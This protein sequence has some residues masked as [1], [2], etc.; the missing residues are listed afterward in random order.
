MDRPGPQTWRLPRIPRTA[1]AFLAAAVCASVAAAQ[2]QADD[3]T[4]LSLEELLQVEVVSAASKFEQ[5]TFQAPS[6]ITIVSAHD[7]RVWGYR[8]LADILRSVPGFWV[9]DDRNYEHIGVR[10]FGPLGDYNTRVLLLVDGHRINNNVYDT[11]PI[12]LEFPLDVELIERVEVVRGP[13][14]ALYGSNAFFGVVNVVTRRGADLAGPELSASGGSFE[15]WRGR[16]SWGRALGDEGDVLLSGTVFDSAGQDFYYEEYAGDPSGGTTSGTDEER[17]FSL[18]GRWSHGEWRAEAA[19]GM[20]RKGIPTGSYGTVFDHPGNWTEDGQGYVDV[21]WRRHV[22]ERFELEARAFWDRYVYRGEYVFDATS[23]GGPPDLV[24]D[25]RG[26]GE[27]AGIELRGT[28]FDL[29]RQVLTVGAELRANLRMDQYN[30]DALGVYT[31]DQRDS[32]VWGVYAQDEVRLAERWRLTLGLRHDD[33]ETFGGSTNPR[34]ALIYQPDE[35]TAWKLIAGRAFRAPNAYEN[36]YDSGSPTFASLEPETIDAYEAVFER[37]FT[38]SLRG[39]VSLYYYSIDDLIVQALDPGSGEFVF[40][41]ASSA[42]G[43]GAEV[44]LEQR[45]SGGLRLRGSYAWQAIE[46]D[47]SGGELPNSPEHMAQVHLE[48]PLF[49]PRLIAGLELQALSSR[50]T[51]AGDEVDPYLVTNLVVSTPRLEG[52]FA[53]SLGL[54]NL[55]D[56]SYADPGPPELVQDQLGQD[57]RTFVISLR[58]SR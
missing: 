28:R 53:A 5:T 20:R 29:P 27:W 58:W 35:R 18:L 11:A 12:G 49:T 34:A 56:E 41:N 31:D 40:Q 6:S 43:P 38:R 54:Y 46:D 23:G 51:L 39:S 44:E 8:S 3:L 37:H 36:Y 17:G 50:A 22:E 30:A 26:D 4:A 7:I 14:S 25:D 32:L 42:S 47:A 15:T 52:G 19:W 9:T 21:A 13:G 1:A 16:A 55:F 57:G 10:G 2:Q 48:A 45:W 24:N 33:Y